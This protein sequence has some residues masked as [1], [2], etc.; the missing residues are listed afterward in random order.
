MMILGVVLFVLVF[1]LIA[2]QTRAFLL[3]LATGAGAFLTAWAP[4]SYVLLLILL[5]APC[6]GMYIVHTWPQRVDEENPMAK[7]RREMPL[8]E[9]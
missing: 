6:V 1:V 5:A 4:F 8:D 9:D 2:P 7:Y 3:V